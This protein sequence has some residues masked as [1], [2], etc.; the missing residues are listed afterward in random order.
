MES[1]D[2]HTYHLVYHDIG[3]EHKKF[4]RWINSMVTPEV[5]AE[6]IEQLCEL[7]TICSL[8]EAFVE[9]KSNRPRRG[10]SFFI[11]QNNSAEVHLVCNV[12]K[13]IFEI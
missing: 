5:F 8:N 9:N 6:H 12:N 10:S 7:G 13:F 3:Y 1:L 4:T 2:N 11:L